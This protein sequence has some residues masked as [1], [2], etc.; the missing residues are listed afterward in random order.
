MPKALRVHH[1]GLSSGELSLTEPTS[2]YVCRVHRLRPGNALL[3]F[4]PEQGVEADAELLDAGAR[5]R[6]R[7]AA[8][9]AGQRPG[10]AGLRLWLGRPKSAAL[11]RVVRDAVAFGVSELRLVDTEHSVPRGQEPARRLSE[12]LLDETRQCERSDLLRVA[13]P[14]SFEQALASAVA[15][16]PALGEHVVL[17][18]RKAGGPLMAVL[19]ALAPNLDQPRALSFWIGPE[20]GFSVDELAALERAGARSALLGEFVLRV[21]TAV[22]AALAAATLAFP[23]RSVEGW[24]SPAS[25]R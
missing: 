22:S 20:A 8:V 6:V 25:A 4:D 15:E 16:S 24:A 7:V 13:E 12:L 5:A 1:P 3:L 10:F 21:P 9:R 23:R 2:R 18:A 11:E 14:C 17:D 19:N